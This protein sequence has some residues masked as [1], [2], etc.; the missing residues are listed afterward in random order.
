MLWRSL[1]CRAAVWPLFV[2]GSLWLVP[3]WLCILS[4]IWI[5]ECQGV[6]LCFGSPCCSVSELNGLFST[7]VSLNIKGWDLGMQVCTLRVKT[8][9]KTSF[10]LVLKNKTNG[11]TA[12]LARI[13]TEQQRKWLWSLYSYQVAKSPMDQHIY[14]LPHYQYPVI[15]SPVGML[16]L[17][18]NKDDPT[19]KR[20]HS[21]EYVVTST[22]KMN[23]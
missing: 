19:W 23:V 8:L 15:Y 2:A 10:L 13:K 6:G 21:S 20:W 3:R 18:W 1:T 17:P 4:K 11:T 9:F 7:A 22:N 12:E 14:V 5:F 16:P